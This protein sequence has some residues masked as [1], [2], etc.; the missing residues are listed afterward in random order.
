MKLFALSYTFLNIYL[1]SDNLRQFPVLQI[2]PS[3]K[4]LKIL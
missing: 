4:S 3:K 1:K 2:S